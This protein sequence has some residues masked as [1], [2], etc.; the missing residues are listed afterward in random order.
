ML[1][2]EGCYHGHSDGLL[3]KSGSGV[4]E[5]AESSS[6]GVPNSIVSE[7]LVVRFDSIES[8]EKAFK[9][10]GK[11]IAAVILEPIPANEGLWV[12]LQAHL[13]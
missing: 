6:Q 13:E 2:F 8:I 4:A 10:Y 5:L 9:Q 11:E 7:T 12:P 1:K 3:A